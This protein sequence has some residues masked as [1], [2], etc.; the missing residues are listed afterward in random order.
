MK[1][2]LVGLAAALLACAPENVLEQGE[3]VERSYDDPDTWWSSICISYN[4]N[5]ACAMSM[6]VQEHDDAHWE[7]KVIGYDKDGKQRSEWHEVTETLFNLGEV[8]VTVNFPE[9]RVVPR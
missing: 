7:L 4:S 3:V 9:M 1:R 5:G 6:P 2:L 8:G